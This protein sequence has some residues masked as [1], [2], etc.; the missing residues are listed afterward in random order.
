MKTKLKLSYHHTFTCRLRSAALIAQYFRLFSSHNQS[1]SFFLRGIFLSKKYADFHPIRAAERN[2]HKLVTYNAV[3]K[4]WLVAVA[5]AK[6]EKM[7]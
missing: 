2:T 7:K 4:Y 6:K 1:A 5:T 3:L